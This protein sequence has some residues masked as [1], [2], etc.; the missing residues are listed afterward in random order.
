MSLDGL[1]T[2]FSVGLSVLHFAV[3]GIHMKSYTTFGKIEEQYGFSLDKTMLFT[4]YLALLL[5]LIISAV[6]GANFTAQPDV[7]KAFLVINWVYISAIAVLVVINKFFCKK[8]SKSAG[9]ELQ[10][11]LNIVGYGI[12]PF[13]YAN[14]SLEEENERLI[15]KNENLKK[16]LLVNR[17]RNIV[18]P[19]PSGI[20][21]PPGLQ[22]WNPVV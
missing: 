5:S 13:E 14:K 18:T 19:Q 22:I 7:L 6:T 2:G 3:Y 21:P 17:L 11:K 10:K 9:R 15:E 4:A 12:N 20:K 1:G 16:E 8:S